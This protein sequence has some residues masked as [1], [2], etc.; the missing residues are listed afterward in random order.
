M[1]FT[2]Y[3]RFLIHLSITE[4]NQGKIVISYV[5]L[6]KKNFRSVFAPQN[7]SSGENSALPEKAG[8]TNKYKSDKIN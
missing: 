5:I 1:A 8:I 3:L 7:P 6:R 2:H 4:K